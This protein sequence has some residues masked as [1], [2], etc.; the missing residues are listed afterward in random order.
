MYIKYINTLSEMNIKNFLIGYFQ[1]FSGV[2]IIILSL[3]IIIT[4][5]LFSK[6]IIFDF[7]YMLLFIPYII[8]GLPKIIDK[9]VD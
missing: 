5:Y 6:S 9:I 1:I 8:V 4:P 2:A 3:I 7:L